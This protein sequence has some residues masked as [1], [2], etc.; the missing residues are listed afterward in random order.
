MKKHLSSIVLFGVFVLGL[1]LLIYPSFSDWWNS[2]VQSHAIM[3]YDAAVQSL[4]QKDY[5]EWFEAAD[6]YNEAVAVLEYPF[7][8][9]GQLAERSDLQPYDELLNGIKAAMA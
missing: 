8:N 3:D 6:A 5:S 4:T 2:R 9:Y 1:A 7:M